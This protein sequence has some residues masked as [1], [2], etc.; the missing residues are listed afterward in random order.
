M[1]QSVDKAETDAA[2]FL[3]KC[4]NGGKDSERLGVIRRLTRKCSRQSFKQK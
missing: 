4:F 1:R 2:A 3:P